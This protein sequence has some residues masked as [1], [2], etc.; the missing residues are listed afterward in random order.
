MKLLLRSLL[1]LLGVLALA[2]VAAGCDSVRPFAVEVDGDEI[3]QSSVD[4]ELRA[5]S[6]NEALAQGSGVSRSDDTLDSRV[7]AFWLTWLVEQQVIDREVRER[8]IDVSGADR[9]SGVADLEAQLGADVYDAFPKWLRDRLAGRFARRQ[10]LLR[11][12]GGDPA[13]PTDAEVRAAYDE[14]L[15]QLKAQCASGTFVA[16]IL[17]ESRADAEALAAQL[18]AGVGF[19]Q[20]ARERSTDPG[21]VDLG[22]ELG[23]LDP[24]QFVP[25]F[26]EAAAALP[27]G[28]VSQPVETEF[29]FHLIRVS[30]TIAFESVEE[31]IRTALEQ[32]AGA[33]SSPEL[34]ELVV[35]AH[36][37]VD[38]RYGTWR[39]SEGQGA[40]EPPRG[41][42]PTTAST[43]APT[44][45][46][47]P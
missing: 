35:A 20:L 42:T 28:Q 15:A 26:S 9:K 39:V 24:A 33:G 5:L 11:D 13:G 31:Q 19:A 14:Q 16:H 6:D 32:E 47:A 7:T 17:V 2:I 10:A 22:G 8:G 29:G 30:D 4:R 12:L 38:P 45:T 1:A 41:A 34:A 18:V 40:V 36:V 23:C 37:R 3:S 21:S 43:P 27:L 46:P 25:E 44:R